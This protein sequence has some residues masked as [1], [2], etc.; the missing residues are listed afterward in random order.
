VTINLIVTY[1]IERDPLA[2]MNMKAVEEIRDTFREV[3]KYG[4][5]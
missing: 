4:I 2:S 5:A 3:E 1:D